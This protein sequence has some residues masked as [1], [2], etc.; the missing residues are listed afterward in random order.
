MADRSYNSTLGF[1]LIMRGRGGVGRASHDR[2]AIHTVRRKSKTTKTRRHQHDSLRLLG[3][4]VVHSV[5]T[6]MDIDTGAAICE[7]K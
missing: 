7:N 6:E 2:L 5:K 3:A 4:E 1:D